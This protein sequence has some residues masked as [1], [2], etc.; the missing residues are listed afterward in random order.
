M[1]KK[2]HKKVESLTRQQLKNIMGGTTNKEWCSA[3]ANCSNGT[4]VTIVCEESTAG[5]VGIDGSESGNGYV[6]CQHQDEMV[7]FVV[8]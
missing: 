3:T 2:V 7:E 6:Y 5:C 1:E 4:S 8:C